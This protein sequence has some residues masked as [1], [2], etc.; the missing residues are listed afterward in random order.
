MRHLTQLEMKRLTGTRV[1][2]EQIIV[3]KDLG[4]PYRARCMSTGYLLGI[5][6]YTHEI[7]PKLSA[8][9]W[10]VIRD[11]NIGTGFRK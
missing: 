4:M 2:S 11:E 6:A 5:T 3:L 9:Q 10:D 8:L 7:K 1:L